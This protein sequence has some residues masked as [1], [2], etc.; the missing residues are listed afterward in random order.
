MPTNSLKGNP[1]HLNHPS[2]GGGPVMFVGFDSPHEYYT[3]EYHKPEF[4]EF[5]SPT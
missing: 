4:L 5:C 2:G 3:Y 1:P